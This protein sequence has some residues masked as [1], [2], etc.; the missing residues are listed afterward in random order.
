LN[1]K[2]SYFFECE[3]VFLK[4]GEVFVAL[5][6]VTDRDYEYSPGYR[7]PGIT[8]TVGLTLNF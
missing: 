3:D 7:M 2:L 4:E 5:E 1:A 8:W 6:N